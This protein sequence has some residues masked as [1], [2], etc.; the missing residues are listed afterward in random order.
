MLSKGG[1]IKKSDKL[2]FWLFWH[3]CDLLC[4]FSASYR[5]LH[6][7]LIYADFGCSCLFSSPQAFIEMASEEA[8]ITMVN[9]Y[10]TATPHVRNQPVYIQYSNHREL[11]T[12]NLPN[13]GVR[14]SIRTLDL[15]LTTA[16]R[17]L[18]VTKVTLNLSFWFL[19]VGQLEDPI[20]WHD[21]IGR[22]HVWTTVPSRNL[23]C[24]LLLENKYCIK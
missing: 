4:M 18:R 13:Q 14:T 8:A 16:D 7:W 2:R 17:D 3:D 5:C 22:G 23:V 9:Y 24:C 21:K 10:T 20:C 6:W 19:S 1:K 12:D 11:K 15:P